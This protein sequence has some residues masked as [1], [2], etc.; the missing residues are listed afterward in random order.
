MTRSTGPS[1]VLKQSTLAMAIAFACL[2]E[3]TATVDLRILETTDIH[4]HLVD[5]DYYQDK[6]S[7][8]LD[9]AKTATLIK[10]A[11]AEVKNSLLFDNSDLIQ[12]NPL[13]DYIAKEQGLTDGQLHPVYKAM[14]LLN[15]DAGNLGNHE[16]NYGLDFLKTSL[17]NYCLYEQRC[18]NNNRSHSQLLL[19]CTR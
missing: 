10:A 5:Y 9:L 19:S 15:Y 8:S 4:V 12:G 16:F 11:R 6:P 3:S 1:T 7:T 18:R 17:C 2:P 14:N 13:G